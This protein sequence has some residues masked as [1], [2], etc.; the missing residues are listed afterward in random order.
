MKQMKWVLFII[1]ALVLLSMAAMPLQEEVTF[2]DGVKLI[3]YLLVGFAGAPLTQLIKNG[4]SSLLGKVVEDRWALLL[5][6]VVAAL[7]ALLEMFLSGQLGGIT[8]DNFWMTFLAVYALAN[9][10][11]AMFKNSEGSVLGQRLLL[12]VPKH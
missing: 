12:K 9:M 2:Q 6:A 11:Y 4:L 7:V 3:L 5:T 10:Y 1:T 8:L